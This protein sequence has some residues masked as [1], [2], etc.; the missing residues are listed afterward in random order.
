MADIQQIIATSP[1]RR[2]MGIETQVD[3]R[4]VLAIMPARPDLIGNTMLPALHG[5]GI[6]AFLEITCLLQLAHEMGTTAPARSIDFSVEYL[7]PGRP[8]TTFAR[9]VVRRMGRRVATVHSEAWQRDE[10]SPICLVRCHFRL[11]EQRIETPAG[12]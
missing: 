6:A 8:E 2:F 11:P 10:A 1:F 12:A 3:E 9:A 5:G 7:R 4:G